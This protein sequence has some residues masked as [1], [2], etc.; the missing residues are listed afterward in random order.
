MH[1]KRLAEAADAVIV[2]SA[3]A[4]GR[5]RTLGAPLPADAHV[6]GSVQRTFAARSTAAAGEFVL[7]AGR[8]TPEKGFAD[9]VAACELA[10]LPLVVA[11]DGPERTRLE[12]RATARF[13]GQI[14]A[15]ELAGLRQRAAVAVVPSRYA[16]ILPLV[17][18]ESMAAGLPIVAARS[19]GLEEAVPEE[20]LYPPGDVRALADR[21][22]A[23]FRDEAAGERA[24]QAVRAR[25]APET[26]AG[27]LAAI[28]GRNFAEPVRL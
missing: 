23:L 7:A 17:A 12:W 4:L 16:E 27:Q 3:F 6:V 1:Q 21:L 20:G 28:Y 10:R 2:P 5:L 11:G 9:V 19:G 25:S 18:L 8:L 13:T 14:G 15:D 26:V 24:L 22:T